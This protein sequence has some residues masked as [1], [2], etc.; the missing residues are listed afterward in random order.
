MLKRIISLALLISIALCACS[1]KKEE[2][3]KFVDGYLT[4]VLYEDGT[5]G[6]E[7]TDRENMPEELVIPA[8]YNGGTVVKIEDS[9]FANCDTVVTVTVPDTIKSLGNGSFYMCDMLARVTLEGDIPSGIGSGALAFV[10]QRFS[11]YYNGTLEQWENLYK[12]GNWN[13]E[14]EYNVYCTDGSLLDQ[15]G[16]E[17]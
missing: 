17:A 16:R 4:Y 10:G 8:T 12:S 7:A 2:R 11:I 15:K 14:S 6:V 3:E 1:C 5:Y 9:G 13:I